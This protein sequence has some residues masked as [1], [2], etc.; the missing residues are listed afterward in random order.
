MN[1][2]KQIVRTEIFGSEFYNKVLGTPFKGPMTPHNDNIFPEMN[3]RHTSSGEILVKTA[4]DM[5]SMYDSDSL[6]AYSD[7]RLER[8]NGPRRYRDEMKWEKL[9]ATTE[10]A[11]VRNGARVTNDRIWIKSGFSAVTFDST[12]SLTERVGYC[13]N[14]NCFLTGYEAVLVLNHKGRLVE[15]VIRSQKMVNAMTWFSAYAKDHGHLIEEGGA[16]DHMQSAAAKEFNSKVEADKQKSADNAKFWNL[17]EKI[18]VQQPV[19]VK[20]EGRTLTVAGKKIFRGP[21]MGG[22]KMDLRHA[23]TTGLL[24]KIVEAVSAAV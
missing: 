13:Q 4:T 20:V 22:G 11:F 2:T 19:T 12:K 6:I 24:P 10:V 18:N 16:F 1:S 14:G 5:V 23:F 8:I 7:G 15:A 21:K 3:V 9:C 17:V